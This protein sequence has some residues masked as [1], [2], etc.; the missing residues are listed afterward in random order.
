MPMRKK[1]KVSKPQHQP[2][3]PP[4]AS[5]KAELVQGFRQAL[6]RLGAQAEV[7]IPAELEDFMRDMRQEAP[8]AE[9]HSRWD[10]K[11]IQGRDARRASAHQIRVCAHYRVALTTSRSVGRVFFLN[12]Y[13]RTGNNA[14]DIETAVRRAIEIRGALGEL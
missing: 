11:Q 1:R 12:A 5:F 9:L 10:Y 13:R 7:D 4:P 2:S 14:A 3:G 6:R 8:L